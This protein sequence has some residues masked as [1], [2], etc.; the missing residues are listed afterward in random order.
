MIERIIIIE[1]VDPVSFY[2][3]NNS[4]MQLIHNLLSWQVRVDSRGIE[5]RRLWAGDKGD[6][7]GWRD[8]GI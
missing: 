8:S 1:N 5:S 4:N 6:R 2:G 3:V 7:G